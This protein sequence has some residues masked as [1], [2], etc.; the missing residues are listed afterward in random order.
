MTTYLITGA[1][2]GIGL[3]LCRQLI[4]RG[5]GVIGVCRRTSDELEDLGARVEAGVDVSSAADVAALAAR[6]ANVSIDVLI[7]NAGVL[8]RTDLHHL[9]FEAIDRQFQVNA[10]GP[11]RMVAAL[12]ARIPSGGKVAV[13]TSRMGSISDNS[14]GGSYGYRMSK[15][16]VNAAFKSLAL[17]LRPDGIAVGILH[18]G[19]VRTDMTAGTGLISAARSA[20]GLIE[21]VDALDLTNSGT[22]WHMDGEILPW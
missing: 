17:D 9:D 12:R 1:N 11:L 19:W 14:S 13:V 16:A 2:R 10:V 4:A 15:A 8:H 6:L 21:R 7:N 20:A 5:E 3:E 18:P 22:F